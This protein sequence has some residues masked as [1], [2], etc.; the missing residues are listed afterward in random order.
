MAYDDRS[1]LTARHVLGKLITRHD[2]PTLL[3]IQL[4]MELAQAGER[5]QPLTRLALLGGLMPKA[6]GVSYDA[7]LTRMIRSPG[8]SAGV[9]AGLGRAMLQSSPGR[10]SWLGVMWLFSNQ[11]Q[12]S[13]GAG[14]GAGE[15]E[16]GGVGVDGQGLGDEVGQLAALA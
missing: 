8:R 2:L 5:A 11:D 15:E 9:R 3:T 13:F 7:S 6:R 1:Q 14:M 10:R 12:V 4:C 16:P